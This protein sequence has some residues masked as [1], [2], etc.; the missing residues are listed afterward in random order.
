MNIS[1]SVIERVREL[2]S[3][4]T[5]SAAIR[6]ASSNDVQIEEVQVDAGVIVANGC[7]YQADRVEWFELS[8][9]NDGAVSGNCTC[10]TDGSACMHAVA[11]MITLLSEIDHAEP[12]P[13]P[14][15][16]WKRELDEV[17]PSIEPNAASDTCLFFSVRP[18]ASRDRWRHSGAPSRPYLAIRPGVRGARDNWIKGNQGWRL[19]DALAP[20]HPA[21]E[22]LGRLRALHA[23]A[24][25]NS[26]YYYYPSADTEWLSLEDIASPEAWQLLNGLRAHG[27]ALI[28]EGKAQHPIELADHPIDVRIA[29]TRKGRSLR[30][31]A[32]VDIPGATTGGIKWLG[33]PVSMAARVTDPGGAAQR[34]TLFRTAEPLT[35][36]AE[37]LLRRKRAITI[38]PEERDEFEQSYLPRVQAEIEVTSPDLSYDIP[39]MRPAELTLAVTFA[40]P[41]VH[42]E[43]RWNRPVVHLRDTA[44]ESAVLAQVREAAAGHAAVLFPADLSGADEVPPDR[45]LGMASAAVLVGEVL[46]RL[47]ELEHVSVVEV[48]AL[49]SFSRSGDLPVVGIDS[50]RDGDWYDLSV[51]VSVGGEEVEFSALF[52]ALSVGDPVFV[53]PSGTYF[54]LD[55]QEFAAL[56]AIIEEAKALTDRPVDRL[57][58]SKYQVD[59]WAELSELGIVA[60]AEAEWWLAVRSLSTDARVEPITPPVGLQAELRPYQQAGY[61]WLDFLRRNGLGGILADDMGLGKTLQTIAMMLRAHQ[62]RADA[63]PFLVVAPTSVV[64]NWAV[65][66]ERFAPSLNV[67]TITAMSTRRGQSLSD[68]VNGADVVVTSYALFRGEAEEYR[69]LS[70]SGLILDEAQQIKNPASLGY[71]AARTLGAPFVLVVTGTPMENNLGELWALTSLAAPGLLGGKERFAD[72][73]RRPIEKEKNTERL[74]LLQR[75]IRP[76]MLR[77]TKGVVAPELPPKQENTIAVDL[78]PRHR[79][80]YDVRFQRE[81]QKVLGLIDDVQANRFQIFRSL[82]LLRQLALD[83]ELVGEGTAP[84]AK[85]DVLVDLLKEASA[86]GHRVL[87]LSQFTRFLTRARERASEAGITTEYLDG[88]TTDRPTVIRRFREGDSHAFFVSL[89]AG[90]FGLNLV[91]ADYVVLLDPWWNPAVEEQA[92]DRTHRIGQTRPVFVYRIVA[93]ETIEQKVIALRESK[94]A[95][96]AQVVD[97][98]GNMGSGSI[99]AEDIRELLS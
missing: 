40:D 60:A 88:S 97:G 43:W 53:L 13:P 96:F 26:Y 72:F 39:P 63:A 84:S 24:Q 11:A 92:V 93:A 4:S 90:G 73:Y 6:I 35:P 41:Q 69:E 85:L 3:A 67:V 33:S 94:A 61:A 30:M 9:G 25:E 14:G 29:I 99:S 44:H 2:V 64:G 7:V 71:R 37:Q 19:V 49:P 32:D 83:P 28:A 76:F 55:G 80:L 50:E 95:L 21:R 87:V 17:L 45:T 78:H 66:C 12:A 98:V 1:P 56:R 15:P 86:E 89:K 18:P 48:T 74:E 65:E 36:V 20:R 38:A 75:R 79:K 82:T 8:M 16:A 5:L 70:W 62:E 51:A 23:L 77:R 68:A 27:V 91:E 10:S 52:T 22:P 59:L 34:I 57:R 47:R 42:V 54:P 58:V 46:P 81:R 31:K